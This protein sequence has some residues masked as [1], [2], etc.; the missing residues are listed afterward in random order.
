MM[1]GRTGRL[2][3]NQGAWRRLGCGPGA[4]RGGGRAAGP[5]APLRHHRALQ[6]AARPALQAARGARFPAHALPVH[7]LPPVLL[8][9]R[10][11]TCSVILG[12]PQHVPA[13]PCRAWR[14]QQLGCSLLAFG[15]HK[16][17]FYFDGRSCTLLHMQLFSFCNHVYYSVTGFRQTRHLRA[18]RCGASTTTSARTRR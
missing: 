10:C 14:T 4:A 18:C 1:W 15:R 3:S 5:A 12:M 16:L 6:P 2:L 13:S 8:P 11:A 17:G 9:T 7:L